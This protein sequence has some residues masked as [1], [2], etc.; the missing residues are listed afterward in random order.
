MF[1]TVTYPPLEPSTDVTVFAADVQID[2]PFAGIGQI[3][4]DDAGPIQILDGDSAMKLLK[5]KARAIGA[6]GLILGRSEPVELDIVSRE[7]TS[8]HWPFGN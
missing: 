3:Y 8:K 4:Y 6:D 7:S 2:E 1:G 5:Q